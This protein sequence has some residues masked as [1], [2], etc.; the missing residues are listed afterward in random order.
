MYTFCS[1]LSFTVQS[2][3]AHK[4][5]CKVSERLNCTSYSFLQRPYIHSKHVQ[6]QSEAQISHNV[7]GEQKAGV[8][9]NKLDWYDLISGWLLNSVWNTNLILVQLVVVQA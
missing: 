7:E 2:E 9:V 8:G 6:S 5:T 3:L 1:V 4:T